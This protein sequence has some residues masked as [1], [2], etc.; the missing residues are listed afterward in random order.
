MHKTL[1]IIGTLVLVGL[2]G[3]GITKNV[4]E[5]RNQARVLL[6]DNAPLFDLS[7]VS[8]VSG[9]GSG[10]SG[11]SGGDSDGVSG[12]SGGSLP[13]CEGCSDLF[14]YAQT[15]LGDLQASQTR[16]NIAFATYRRDLAKYNLEYQKYTKA[17]SAWY[18]THK[19]TKPT[20]PKG[21]RPT[22]PS[23]AIVKRNRA[24]YNAAVDSYQECITREEARAARGECLDVERPSLEKDVVETRPAILR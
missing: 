2:V 23:D 7:G 15:K 9:G 19:G 22:P 17:M 4:L 14:I 16:Y 3:H 24:L 21:P 6:A 11:V 8:G 18:S 12:V 10:V 20:P 1:A 13:D 5:S